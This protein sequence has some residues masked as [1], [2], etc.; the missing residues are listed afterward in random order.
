MDSRTRHSLAELVRADGVALADDSQRVKALL[1]DACPESRTEVALLVSAAE[2]EIPSRLLRS[3]DSVF[4]EGE[5]ARAVADLQRDRRLDRAAAEWV[6]GSWAWALGISDE[7]PDDLLGEGSSAEQRTVV[8]S[9]PSSSGP[10]GQPAQVPSSSAS[11]P[12]YSSSSPASGQ[13]Q[14]PFD[15]GPGGPLPP[16]QGGG[17]QDGSYGPGMPTSGPPMSGPPI[18]GPPGP[19][20]PWTASPPPNRPRYGLIFGIVAAVIVLLLGGAVAVAFAATQGHATQGHKNPTPAPVPPAP[21]STSSPSPQSANVTFTITD[22]LGASEV[23]EKVVVYFNGR[24]YAKLAIDTS[25]PTDSEP[26]TA[27]E[28]GVYQYQIDV[29]YQYIDGNG[30]LQAGYTSGQ[31]SIEVFQGASYMVDLVGPSNNLVAS[32]KSS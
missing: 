32:L 2:D 23:S 1:M 5:M 28:P 10:S 29:T 6:V 26:L 3:S 21:T 9:G 31:G 30:V 24:Q 25:S 20:S 4:R 19:M 14:A 17:W 7:E 12:D 8:T 13:W 27:S 22:Q 11:G 15:G 16:Q 18:S